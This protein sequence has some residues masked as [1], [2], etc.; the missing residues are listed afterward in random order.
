MLI[1][2]LREEGKKGLGLTGYNRKKPAPFFAV[3]FQKHII[4]EEYRVFS[5]SLGVTPGL[6]CPE[7]QGKKPPL[8]GRSLPG[9][10]GVSPA[11]NIPVPVRPGKA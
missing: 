9:K 11:E 5:R 7:E 3:H 1:G 8:A 6:G 10:F 2:F 4:Q